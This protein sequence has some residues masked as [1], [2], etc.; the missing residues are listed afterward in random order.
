MSSRRQSRTA[1]EATKLHED[2]AKYSATTLQ[3]FIP[4]LVETLMLQGWPILQPHGQKHLG[5]YV[6]DNSLLQPLQE[7]LSQ[8]PSLLPLCPR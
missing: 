8:A 7:T 5:L 1:P 6:G 3:S 4:A 2:M